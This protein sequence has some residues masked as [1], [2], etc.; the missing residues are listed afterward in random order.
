[1]GLPKVTPAECERE[2]WWTPLSQWAE[3]GDPQAKPEEE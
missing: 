1:M 2:S 3:D